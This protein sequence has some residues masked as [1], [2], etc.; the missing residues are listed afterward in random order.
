MYA[1]IASIFQKGGYTLDSINELAKTHSI[2]IT[3]PQERDIAMT[4][5][6]LPETIDAV[7]H[8]LQINKIC[9]MLF[10]LSGNIGSFYKANK[11]LGSEEEKSRILLLEA[12]RKTMKTLFNLLGMKTLD[13]I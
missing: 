2:K 7:F 9:K 6:R 3:S 5:L 4:I 10:D 1:R 8:D 13:R 12:T 11:V